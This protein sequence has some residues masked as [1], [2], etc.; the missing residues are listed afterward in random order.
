MLKDIIPFF[1]VET[2]TPVDAPGTLTITAT[3]ISG[4]NPYSVSITVNDTDGITSITSASLASTD[5]RGNRDLMGTGSIKRRDTN[6]FYTDPF[7]FRNAR[8]ATGTA[9]VTYTDGLG[10]IATIT[11]NWSIR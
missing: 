6:T 7:A 5:G 2:V 1:V 4:R 8:W 3:R 11:Q 10:N 9:S